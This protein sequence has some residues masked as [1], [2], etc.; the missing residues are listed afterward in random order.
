MLLLVDALDE[1]LTYTG[2]I[3]IVRLLA[4]LDDLPEQVRFL[5]TS[6]PD[7]RV[8]KNFRQA[9][10]VDLIEDAPPDVDDVQAY[11]SGRLAKAEGVPARSVGAFADRIAKAADGIF[12]YAAI[13][14]DELLPRLPSLANLDLDRYP[15]PDGLSGLY[16]DFLNRELGQDE[17]RWYGH[18]KPVLGL[19]AVAQGDG[20]TAKQ[21]GAITGKEVEQTLRIS[22]QYLSGEWPVGPFRCFHRSFV[23]WLLEDE[24][25]VDYHI[26]GA[27]M[28]RQIADH[29]WQA[30]HADWQGCNAYGLDALATHLYE[31]GQDD[32]L[33]ALISQAWMAA[34]FE[35]SGYTYDGFIEDVKLAWQ[36]AHEAA[37]RQIKADQA[38]A[39]LAECVRYALIRTSLNSQAANY[40]PALVA[41]AVETGLWTV[42]RALSVASHAPDPKERVDMLTA[43]LATG[44]LG[45][46]QSSQAEEAG[47]Q[48]ALAIGDEWHRARALAALAP[49]L[50]G[51]LLARG[52]EAALAIGDE[53]YRADV[54]A[55]LAPQLTGELLARGLEAAVTIGDE[56]ARARLL[57]ALAPRLTG[58]ALARGLEAALGIADEAY[59][60]SALAALASQ[61]S[62]EARGKALARGLEAL[63]AALTPRLAGEALARGLAALTPQLTGEA[64]TQGL[65]A[66]LAI[67]DEYDRARALAGLASQLTGEAR[68]Q[69]LARGLEVTPDIRDE[70]LRAKALAALAPQ[71]TGEAREQALA[72]GLE[73]AVTIEDEYDRARALAALAPHLT[74]EARE[75][76]LARGLEAAVGIGD[77]EARAEAPAALAPQLSGEAREQTWA[78]GLYEVI[79]ADALAAL[80]PQLT[81]GLL[82][83]AL[84]A[85]IAIGD[86]QYRTKAL[87][88]LAPQLTGEAL[89]R[90]LEV[91][92]AIGNEEHRAEVLTGLAPQL[93]GEALAR[94]LEAALAIG[95]EEARAQALAALAPQLTGEALARGLEAALAIGDEEA[96]ARALAALAPQLTGEAREQVLE[97][98][99]DAALAV[100]DERDRVRALVDLAPHLTGEALERALVGALAIGDESFR[101]RALVAFL[102][103][104]P[105]P[106]AVLRSARQAIANHL[107]KNLSAAKREDLLRFCAEERLLAPPLL[108]RDTLAAIAWHIVEV[109]QAW[110]WM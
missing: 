12:L 102:H 77:E 69:V 104:A 23:D 20:L 91:A 52:L 70:V 6:R 21:L 7:P 79:R 78:W 41:R 17:D 34:R 90:G 63:L 39:A 94:G 58:K 1:A 84:D 8:L 88:A 22:R 37:L 40:L 45:S 32:R 61:L 28:H 62:G 49:H 55:G 66:A 47:L 24:E 85:A 35:G 38:P 76:A 106:A 100:G 43:L 72:R 14:L 26:D 75:Q 56:R 105:D 65:A 92:L 4:K 109:C 16:Y 96:R 108:D 73:A 3:D 71:L 60:A 98:G 44:R 11:A 87:A 33:Q 74:G 68:E 25:N 81:G 103:A 59:R 5:V 15:L 95:D 64:L 10:R 46:E 36:E 110:R 51:E 99:L 57:A 27:A 13:V 31:A 97:R 86:E 93:T 50:T 19:I 54:L 42:D 83:R 9:K 89:A 101:A 18:F 29:Y 80:A 53:V 107:L 67:E 82:E 2:V 30:H 48:A